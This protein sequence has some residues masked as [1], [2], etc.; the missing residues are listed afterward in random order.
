[1]VPLAPPAPPVLRPD[2]IHLKPETMDQ[3]RDVAPG[4]DKYHLEGLWRDWIATKAGM[5]NDPD[6]A[7]LGWCRKFTKG[8]RPS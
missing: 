2:Q 1:V 4:W 6:K 7:F 8:K 3:V 5:P